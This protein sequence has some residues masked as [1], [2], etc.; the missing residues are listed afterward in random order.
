MPQ[1]VLDAPTPLTTEEID[2][3]IVFLDDVQV[4]EVDF[5]DL[6]LH[7]TAEVN[8][9]YDRVEERI[10]ETGEDLWFFLVNYSR[11]RIDP[12][13]WFAFSRR[14][15]TLN[16]AHSMG[17][18]R[19]DAS[20]ET[21]RQIER[22]AGTER[23]DANLFADRDSAL[24]RLAE[25]PSRRLKKIVHVP[26]YGPEEF[27]RR[28]S[29]DAEEEIM[30]FDLHGLTFHHS[31]D[32]DDLYDVAERRIEDTGRRWYF[33]VNYNDCHI[34]PEAWVQWAKRGKAL[35]MGGSLGSVRY[36]T[37]SETEEEIRLRAQSQ[38]FRPNVRNTRAEALE[39]LAEMKAEAAG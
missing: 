12:E 37:G 33:L 1:T 7:D 15:K 16:M 19:Y 17:S 14:G 23:F 13:A 39:R 29:F 38:G 11:S 25:L 8:T 2:R 35:N 9:F 31:R 21:R 6:E 20:E 32:V 4:M 10:H 30:V 27:E 3:R 18:V 36:A 5:S 26:N 22:D 28:I 34:L 24:K